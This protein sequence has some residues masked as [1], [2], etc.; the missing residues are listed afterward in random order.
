MTIVTD[1]QAMLEAHGV[2]RTF[3]TDEIESYILE[4]KMLCDVPLNGESY[5][6]YKPSFSGD[7]YVTQQYPLQSVTSIT[8]NGVE[9]TPEK[10][11]NEGVIY[12]S[13]TKQGKL[14]VQYTVGMSETDISSLLVPLVVALIENKVGLN[15]SSV[16]E[17]DV[18]VTYN[19]S[20]GVSS[21]TIDSLVEEIRERY[22]SRVMLL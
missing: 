13:S 18:S 9:V 1:I 20:T 3:T 19:N 17:G 16:T 5:E 4:A 7:T 11:T 12:F 15:L 2:T 21:T 14:V 22:S 10:V 8:L 6:D